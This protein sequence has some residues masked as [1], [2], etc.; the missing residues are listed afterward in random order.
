MTPDAHLPGS[1]RVSV[2]ERLLPSLAFAVAAISG[3][4]G[5]G[6]LIR[7]FATLRQAETAGYAAFFGGIAEIE[8]VVGV[9]LV[10]AAVLCAIGIIVSVVTLFT[11]NTTASPPGL[12][13]LMTGLLSLVPPF[14]LHYV[15]HMMK[16]IVSSPTPTEGG[17]SRVADTFMTLAP[18]AL[19]ATALIALVLLVF[20]F[21]PFSS[22][23]GRKSSP[24]VCLL[25]VEIVI[26][27]LIGVYFWEARTSIAERDKD[28]VEEYGQPIESPTA[29]PDPN[30]YE[31]DL[32]DIAN[33]VDNTYDDDFDPNPK[34]GSNTIYGGVLNSKAIDLPEPAYPPAAR[35]VRASGTVTVQVTVNEKG[36]VIS[37]TAVSGHPLLRAAAVQAAR[38]ARFAPFIL[39]G[40][41]VRAKGV[42]TFNFSDQ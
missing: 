21:I 27:V 6:M 24:L 29:T 14:A 42:V 23:P 26:A 30:S 28:R 39:G 40:E 4:V 22:R 1:L 38:K 20:P 2:L 9:V 33:G 13:F 8:L 35:A 19:V 11:A 17:V 7:F 18:F 36:E 34:P 16:G 10:V 12:L 15:V 41:L 5:V 31:G 25:L 37:A 32:D 3:A